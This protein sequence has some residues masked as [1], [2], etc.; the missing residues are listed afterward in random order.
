MDISIVKHK[1][2][3]I[4]AK[5]PEDA[6]MLWAMAVWAL[7]RLKE[8]NPQD[9]MLMLTPDKR[10]IVVKDFEWYLNGIIAECK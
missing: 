9:P 2:I 5:T 8:I 10:V 7:E 4:K 6:V 1:E 3:T